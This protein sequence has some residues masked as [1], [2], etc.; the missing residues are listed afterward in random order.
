MKKKTVALNKLN[1]NK[2][3]ITSLSQVT[4]GYDVTDYFQIDFSVLAGICKETMGCPPPP[5]PPKPTPI[6]LNPPSPDMTLTQLNL[7][8][9]V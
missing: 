6:D 8:Q 4:G 9:Y 2:K 1:L 5:K 3:R 7:C